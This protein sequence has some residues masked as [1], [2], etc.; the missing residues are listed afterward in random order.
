M[1]KEF[2]K[3]TMSEFVNVNRAKLEGDIQMAR[4]SMVKGPG[5]KYIEKKPGAGC[6]K[7]ICAGLAKLDG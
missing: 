7:K 5:R 3:G 2:N 4:E 6:N 1:D